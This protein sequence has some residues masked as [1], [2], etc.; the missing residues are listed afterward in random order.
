MAAL[1]LSQQSIEER[2]R[3]KLVG[4]FGIRF[5]LEGQQR[6]RDQVAIE[7]NYQSSD[8]LGHE[9]IWFRKSA[10]EHNSFLTHSRDVTISKWLTRRNQFSSH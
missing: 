6:Q 10:P 7:Y 1:C 3:E 4:Q 8:L 2:R 5:C 9:F